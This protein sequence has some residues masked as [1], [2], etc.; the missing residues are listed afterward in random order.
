MQLVQ[1]RI[2]AALPQAVAIIK[3]PVP[4][5]SQTQYL[6]I[7]KHGH[8]CDLLYCG[9]ISILTVA[10]SRESPS[11]SSNYVPRCSGPRAMLN[12]YP[13]LYSKKSAEELLR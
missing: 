2:S 7:L 9:A 6:P 1:L 3:L 5:S 13:P 11:S 4:P 10:N 8:Y 12:L